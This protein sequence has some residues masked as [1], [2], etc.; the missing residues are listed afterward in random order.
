MSFSI[1]FRS[2]T[3]IGLAFR[4]LISDDE[5]GTKASGLSR[6]PLHW[7]PEFF[8]MKQSA[9][10][11][12]AS[13][14]SAILDLLRHESDTLIVRSS[15]AGETLEARG[16][17]KSYR[18]DCTPGAVRIAAR[19]IID[20]ARSTGIG[21]NDIFLIVQRYVPAELTG[22]LSNERRVSRE[23][24][25]WRVEY[26][27][28]EG[29]NQ[30][31]DRFSVK[32]APPSDQISLQCSTRQELD[33][34]L[35]QTCQSLSG[36][37]ERL[38]LEW[39]WG[40]GRLWLLQLD[41]ED[42][43]E[44]VDPFRVCSE[45]QH[46]RERASIS[47]PLAIDSCKGW[48]KAE[49]LKRFRRCGLSAQDIYILEGGELMHAIV[50]G[51][52]SQ[53]VRDDIAALASDSLVIRTDCTI[54]DSGPGFNLPR[55]DTIR[56]SVEAEA[57]LQETGSKLVAAGIPYD[58]FCFLLHRFIPAAGCAFAFS[59]PGNP[60]VRIDATWGFPESL[61]F[62]PHDS[63]EYD[64]DEEEI[65]GKRIRC[66][67]SLLTS[68]DNGEWVERRCGSSWD[69][70]QSL[71]ADQ[72]RLISEGTSRLA[73]DMM[74]PVGVMFL[75]WLCDKGKVDSFVPFFLTE[76]VSAEGSSD[77][78]YSGRPHHVVRGLEDLRRLEE[79]DVSKVSLSIQPDTEFLRSNEFLT[80]LAALAISRSMAIEL[81][82][83]MLA[84][85]FY[86]LRHAGARV[87]CI[88]PLEA[89]HVS[90][91]YHGKL[92]RDLIPKRIEER[93][94]RA[95]VRVAESKELGEYL[96]QKLIEEAFEAREENDAEALIDELADLVEIERALAGLNG[97]DLSAVIARADKKRDS[98]GGFREG[99]LLLE[100][101]TL[102]LIPHQVAEGRLFDSGGAVR[103]SH[104]GERIGASRQLASAGTSVG[105]LSIS[106]IPPVGVSG[107]HADLVVDIGVAELAL[108][109]VIRYRGSLVH[110]EIQE[111]IEREPGPRQLVL[112]D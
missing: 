104:V 28:S 64:L 42:V 4:P 91:D 14:E 21:D 50:A 19:S 33:R 84:H 83:S 62:F 69:Y 41:V 35:F 99:Y 73:L 3:L 23:S 45:H 2:K 29:T 65:V 6:L 79:S 112:F 100:A 90:R 32:R 18:C 108:Q 25:T 37:R 59:K 80:R 9:G 66:K 78:G 39:A 70:K 48:R 110:I 111:R 8:V 95:V 87:R 82:G 27:D 88:E 81:E 43:A 103:Q 106:L 7:R 13:L 74:A 67:S 26:V 47:M 98:R 97:F 30:S 92:V 96:K 76:N 15:A 61:N 44:G 56:S 20:Q 1:L 75:T 49:A 63:F 60:R 22:H 94:G 57:F 10:A 38:H 5:G 46:S 16:Q 109:A 24:T 89:V 40:E 17:L 55:S 51:R 68:S 102:P 85:C 93:G 34:C 54:E 11:D 77:L 53:S 86:V 71:T 107:G 58:A 31:H 101:E 36:L 72:V 105:K 12:D 52:I